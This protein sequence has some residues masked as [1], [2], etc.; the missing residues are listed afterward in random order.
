M[1]TSYSD[2]D[3]AIEWLKVKRI[4]TTTEFLGSVLGGHVYRGN[5][6]SQTDYELF[7]FS[8]QDTFATV[9]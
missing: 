5:P 1:K 2:S 6:R 8:Y 7:I 9:A 3:F 4:Y